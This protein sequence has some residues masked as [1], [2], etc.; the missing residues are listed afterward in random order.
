MCLQR[1]LL[2][3]EWRRLRRRRSARDDR[4]ALPRLI[5][6]HSSLPR[7]WLNRRN[8]GGGRRGLRLH[9]RHRRRVAATLRLPT[10]LRLG[11]LGERLLRLST[12]RL[13][14]LRLPTLRLRL[15]GRRP[16][17]LCLLGRGLLLRLAPLLPAASLPP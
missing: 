15:L 2:G 3:L 4:S 1:R 10:L 7:L 11:L 16:L 6:R 8:R 14:T 5:R 12:L 13:P 9:G 17:R